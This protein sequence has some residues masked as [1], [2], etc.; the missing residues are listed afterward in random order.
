MNHSEL[1]LQKGD[2]DS[3][4]SWCSLNESKQCLAHMDDQQ[5]HLALRASL[6]NFLPKR[7]FDTNF[8]FFPPLLLSLI[9]PS[10]SFNESLKCFFFVWIVE[11]SSF[12]RGQRL[13]SCDFSVNVPRLLTYNRNERYTQMIISGLWNLTFN[14]SNISHFWIYMFVREI[15]VCQCRQSVAWWVKGQLQVGQ[16]GWWGL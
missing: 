14:L 7:L 10:Y 15:A 4:E 1:Y 16:L 12:R 3:W 9:N 13:V 11:I 8:C 5:H 2:S 6:K